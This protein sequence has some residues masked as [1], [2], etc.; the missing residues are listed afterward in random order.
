MDRIRRSSQ[1]AWWKHKVLLV[2]NSKSGTTLEPVMAERA[3]REM[4]KMRGERH[5]GDGQGE[6]GAASS[7]GEEWLAVLHG[8]G[9]HRRTFQRFSQVGLVFAMLFGD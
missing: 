5:R 1:T 3:L 4:L 7:G 6:G 8:A 9:W 2:V